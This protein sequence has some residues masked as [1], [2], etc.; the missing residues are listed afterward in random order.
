MHRKVLE[1][2]AGGPQEVVDLRQVGAR[3]DLDH[4]ELEVG[5]ETRGEVLDH[6]V[7]VQTEFVVFRDA[8][9]ATEL[10]QKIFHLQQGR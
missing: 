4:G 10:F 6:M 8:A 7:V 2:R 3:H 1:G 5:E 9:G